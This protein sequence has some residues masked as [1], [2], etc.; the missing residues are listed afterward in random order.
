M[1]LQNDQT[2]EKS[3]A[4]VE[5]IWPPLV[6]GLRPMNKQELEELA[7]AL[8]KP[9]DRE[10]LKLR[11]STAISSVVRLSRL[12]S[13]A[14][15]RNRLKQVASE[16]RKWL[17]QVDSDPIKTLLVH[18]AMHERKR[19]SGGSRRTHDKQSAT[20]ADNG[21]HLRAGRFRCRGHR[22]LR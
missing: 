7:T 15:A 19:L 18:T 11:M 14:Q 17:D 10:H 8:E 4:G 21:A 2:P 20:K 9:V 13:P 1:S 22:P 6:A 3:T 12:P 5:N 16:G